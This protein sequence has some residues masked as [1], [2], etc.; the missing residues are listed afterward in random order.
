MK[1][2]GTFLYEIGERCEACRCLKEGVAAVAVGIGIFRNDAI[3]AV[4]CKIK[5]SLAQIVFF[6]ILAIF[7]ICLVCQITILL[8]SIYYESNNDFEALP[9]LQHAFV[10]SKSLPPNHPYV[11]AGNVMYKCVRPLCFKLSQR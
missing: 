3:D 8:G 1:L 7:Y 5:F 2:L 4:S 11:G 10:A 6:F 9:F